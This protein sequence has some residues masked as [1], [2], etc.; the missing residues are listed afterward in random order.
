MTN[1]DADD[2]AA[3]ATPPESISDPIADARMN[4]ADLVAAL[5]LLALGG[6][7][8][9]GAW[10]MDRLEIRRINPLTAPGLVPGL[11]SLALILCAAIL[12]IRSIRRAAPGGW[13]A[14]RAAL[15]SR[16]AQRAGIVIGLVLIYTLG[17]V[18]RI[19]FWAA[20]GLFVFTFVMVFEVWIADPK[21]PIRVSLP[22]AAGLAIVTA[23]V[24]TLVFQYG[25][26]VRLP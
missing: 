8:L 4:R 20:T 19:P 2:G 7:M 24:V 13:A 18:G 9:F 17:L 15:V 3:V 23:A 5:F 22:W 10:T 16:S 1:P 25:F 11:L 21:R 6:A 12:A 26:L 14:L